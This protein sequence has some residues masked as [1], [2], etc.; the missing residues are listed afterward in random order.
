MHDLCTASSVF[1]DNAVRYRHN[2]FKRVYALHLKGGTSIR[3]E[4]QFDDMEK[5]RPYHFVAEAYPVH[6]GKV[7]L[8]KVGKRGAW[9]PPGGHLRYTSD[10]SCFYLETPEEA[11]VREV[12]EETGLDVEIVESH[13]KYETQGIQQLPLP[14]ILNLHIDREHDHLG[15]EYFC[16]VVGHDV[17]PRPSEE[18]PCRW[19][20]VDELES[21]SSFEGTR[22]PSDVRTMAM[23]AIRKIDRLQR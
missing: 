6:K 3:D 2:T 4:Q 18:G 9:L 5:R 13:R 23:Q 8:V 17:E 22:I 20:S 14:E 12:K 21:L 11:A 16:I 7:L 1:H 15:F 19:F 10:G